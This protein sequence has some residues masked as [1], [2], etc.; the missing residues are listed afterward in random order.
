MQRRLSAS[1]KYMYCKRWKHSLSNKHPKP[2]YLAEKK[3]RQ[4]HQVKHCRSLTGGEVHKGH[5]HPHGISRG[6]QWKRKRNG[7]M[8]NE[9]KRR[10]ML[11]SRR[12]W[13]VG[14]VMKCLR[15]RWPIFQLVVLQVKFLG[16]FPPVVGVK[17]VVG[18]SLRRV[19]FV[20][21]LH[22]RRS[23][24]PHS[25]LFVVPPVPVVPAKGR[26]EWCRSQTFFFKQ[27]EHVLILLSA[28]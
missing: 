17:E 10:P 4:K 16:H 14:V 24:H 13:H 25:L 15:Q 21:G 11:V 9:P 18:A 12:C 20:H 22:A 27:W 23:C 3:W 1:E 26:S 19:R 6:L 8:R 2:I 5:L 28:L 7:D